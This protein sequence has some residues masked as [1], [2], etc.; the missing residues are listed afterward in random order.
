MSANSL[1]HHSAQLNGI[2]QHYVKT[3]SGPAVMLLHGWPQTWYEW[4]HVIRLL[5]GKFTVIAPDLRGFGYS[6][7]PAS[8]YD[9]ATIAADLAALAAHLG[10]KDV[11]V[12]G[13]DWGAVFGYVYAASHPAEVSALGIVDM[14]LPGLGIMEKAISPA[15]GGNFLW[16]MGFQSVPDLPELLIQGKERPY[17]QWFYEHFAYDPS[18]ISASDI[19]VYVA[20]ITQAGALRAGLAVYQ[21]FFTIAEQVVAHAKRPLTI[22]VHAFGGEASLAGLTLTCAKAVAPGAQG[23]VIER[24]GH[25]AAE[26]RPDF[27][28][29]MV[30][31]LVQA[32]QRAK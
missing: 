31:E 6:S 9:A 18:A 26:E 7:K 19:D 25:W 24:C 8:G 4:R 15:P 32:G 23:G 11:T 20:A 28:A 30:R 22:P 13:H 16:H 2:K 17:L 1:E 14:V 29:D 3:G 12:V 5:G 27:V 10:L 21:N